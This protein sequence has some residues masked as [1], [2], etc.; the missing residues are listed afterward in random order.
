VETTK[1]LVT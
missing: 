1:Q